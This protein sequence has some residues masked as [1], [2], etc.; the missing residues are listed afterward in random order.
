MSNAT[1][2]IKRLSAVWTTECDYWTRRVFVACEPVCLLHCPCPVILFPAITVTSKY[3]CTISM[4][5]SGG[6]SSHF[7]RRPAE[8]GGLQHWLSDKQVFSSCGSA[9]GAPNT[10]SPYKILD[11][12]LAVS[13]CYR[14]NFALFCRSTL[15]SKIFNPLLLKSAVKCGFPYC[16]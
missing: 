10:P 9:H 13:R 2:N 3:E 8:I 1:S 16:F 6:P 7:V 11:L 4:D 14:P 5:Q 15:A 12:P